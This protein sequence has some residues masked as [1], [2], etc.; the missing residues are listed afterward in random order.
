VKCKQDTNVLGNWLTLESAYQQR[1]LDQRTEEL[2]ALRA[3]PGH[4]RQRGTYRG[5][6]LRRDPSLT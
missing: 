1:L 5:R 3:Y 6:R 2:S 4:S